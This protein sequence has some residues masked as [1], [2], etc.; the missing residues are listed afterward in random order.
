MKLGPCVFVVVIAA[1][2]GVRPALA[3]TEDCMR[4]YQSAQRQR[5][6]S[7]LLEARADLLTCAQDTCPAALRKDCVGWLAEVER[8]IPAIA[9]QVR[10]ADGCDRPTATTWIDGSVVARAAEGRPIEMNP[11]PHSVRAEVDGVMVEQT[12]VVT[13][14]DQRRI[15]V[16]SPAAVAATC[17]VAGSPSP[18]KVEGPAAPPTREGGRPVPALAYVLGGVGLAG[19]GVGTGFG[20]SAW[21]QKGTLDGCKGACAGRDVDTMRRTF[22]VSDV[23]MGVGIASLA[24]AT[25]LYLTR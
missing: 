22:L 14:G 4:A 15:V 24:V 7:K 5:M 25:F 3:D 1:G 8:T 9:V 13:A 23:A 11:G 17:G 21:S 12:V 10:G 16:L 2:L 20:I 18:V 19:I 6:Q